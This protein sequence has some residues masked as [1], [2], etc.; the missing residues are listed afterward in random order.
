VSVDEKQLDEIIELA[1]QGLSERTKNYQ[2]VSK[3]RDMI[4]KE[5][6]KSKLKERDDE[7]SSLKEK[8]GQYNHIKRAIYNLNL[9]PQVNEELHRMQREE[10]EQSRSSEREQQTQQKKKSSPK[11]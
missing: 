1:K 5:A 8:V 3:M 2:L 9:V 6:H 7:I 11:R 4:P 10:Q